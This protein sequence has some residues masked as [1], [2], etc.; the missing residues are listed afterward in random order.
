MKA[1][2]M[3][4]AVAAKEQIRNFRNQASDEAWRLLANEW[5]FMQNPTQEGGGVFASL[6]EKVKEIGASGYELLMV[7]GIIGLAVSII[8]TAISLLFSSSAQKKEEKKSQAF[9]ICICGI[10]LFSVFS[11]IGFFKSIGSG[12]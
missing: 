12:L 2:L 11:I 8:M 7:I 9:I 3:L 1:V 6:I 4:V 5:D 10:V